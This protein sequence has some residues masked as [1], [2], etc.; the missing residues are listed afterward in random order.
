MSGPESDAEGETITLYELLERSAR[1]ALEL[2]RED[3][4]FPPGRNGVY[5]EPE[6]PVRTTSHW[7]TTLSKVYEIT[8]D[9][10]FAEAANDAADYLLSDEAR[11]Y[12]Y[13]FH[14]RNAEGKDKCD[15]LIG[16][17]AP[18]RGLT[19]AGLTLERPELVEV[20]R[21]VVALHPFNEQLGLWERVEIDGSFQSFDRTLNHQITFAAAIANFPTQCKDIKNDLRGFL[22]KLR[23]NLRID[24]DGVIKH[25]VR[26]PL[27][28]VI[29]CLGS[30]IR[31]WI[32]LLNELMFHYYLYS[33]NRRV[34]EMSYQPLN[35][36]GLARLKQRFPNHILWEDQSIQKS[37]DL[38]KKHFGVIKNTNSGSLVPG[39]QIAYALSVFDDCREIDEYIAVDVNNRFNF[40]T[41]LLSNN[42]IDPHLT[43]ASICNAV[44]L[45]DVEI[46]LTSQRA[47]SER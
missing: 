40:E 34:K 9:E 47:L 41:N 8:G 23:E 3:G 5:D 15:G 10:V 36:Y 37:L 14:S 38:C 25:Y 31:H 22:D 29:R 28:E 1:A 2:Q 42:V 4:S 33:T 6:T 26:P 7:L 21:D 19:R 35:L 39:I 30:N 18:I 13:T 43:S 45:S 32:L 17:A 12:G 46:N 20:A 44:T 24:N 16:Q 27:L 11:P